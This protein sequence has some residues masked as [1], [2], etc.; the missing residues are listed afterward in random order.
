MRRL[1]ELE[2]GGLD[3]VVTKLGI[4]SWVVPDP[5]NLLGLQSGVVENSIGKPGITFGSLG[6]KALGVRTIP[7]KPIEGCLQAFTETSCPLFNSFSATQ[8]QGISFG[9]TVGLE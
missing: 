5:E 8:F 7:V 9:T 2:H 1:V 6:I 4:D 3:R